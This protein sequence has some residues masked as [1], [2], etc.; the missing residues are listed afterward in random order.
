ME[1]QS[2]ALLMGRADWLEP[3]PR[4]QKSPWFLRQTVVTTR[5]KVSE[6]WNGVPLPRRSNLFSRT[7][8]L[9]LTRPALVL[10]PPHAPPHYWRG[11]DLQSSFVHKD[12]QRFPPS[13]PSPTSSAFCPHGLSGCAWPIGHARPKSLLVAHATHGFTHGRVGRVK[14]R[15]CPLWLDEF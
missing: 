8:A 6:W 14:D 13:L 2:T 10:P 11:A 1:E 15:A 9:S 5:R 7:F 12:F 4:L 3:C